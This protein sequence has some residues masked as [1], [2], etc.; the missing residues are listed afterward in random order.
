[1]ILLRQLSEPTFLEGY[2]GSSYRSA[3]N[4]IQVSVEKGKIIAGC[5]DE[6]GGYGNCEEFNVDEI[7]VADYD[8][9][10]SSHWTRDMEEDDV[11][12]E[13]HSLKA[14][15]I[16]KDLFVIGETIG[17]DLDEFLD[18]W[19]AVLSDKA[20]FSYQPETVYANNDNALIRV[21]IIRNN[22]EAIVW[23]EEEYGTGECTVKHV[24]EVT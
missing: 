22:T 13:N 23:I 2:G 6:R 17:L 12:S 19:E 21:K 3:G 7:D 8:S 9:Y 11:E 4:Y 15:D 10:I 24:E 14:I 16:A 1:M 18:G 5:G 20:K